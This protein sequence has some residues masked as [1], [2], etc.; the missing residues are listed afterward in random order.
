MA[1]IK[2]RLPVYIVA[3]VTVGFVAAYFLFFR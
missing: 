3:V 2:E 1:K